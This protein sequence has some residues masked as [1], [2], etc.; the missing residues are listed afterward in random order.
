VRAARREPGIEITPL[1]DVVFLLLIFFMVSSNFV[2]NRVI[3]VSLPESDS[4]LAGSGEILQIT[5]SAA[6]DYWVAGQDLGRDIE[7]LAAAVDD[8]ARVLT[9]DQLAAQ[10]VEIRADANATH[11]SVIR[12]FDAC[13]SAG[14]VQVSLAT[15]MSA[16]TSE[17][18]LSQNSDPNQ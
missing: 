15:A 18:A 7:S 14:F 3:H 16:Q 13:A 6:G 11:Q 10:S 4:A 2:Q 1:I 5:V 8:Y 17:F 12:V 9:V